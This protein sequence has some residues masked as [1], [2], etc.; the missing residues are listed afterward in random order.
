MEWYAGSKITFLRDGMYNRRLWVGIAEL[1]GCRTND[2]QPF[3]FQHVRTI[4]PSMTVNGLELLLDHN[5]HRNTSVLWSVIVE[6]VEL[7]VPV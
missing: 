6:I 2:S 5:A 1:N 7:Q 3:Y 4:P